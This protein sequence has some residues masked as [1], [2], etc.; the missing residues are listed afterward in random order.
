MTARGRFLPPARLIRGARRALAALGG[1]VLLAVAT[2][3]PAL[4]HIGDS[5]G[6]GVH[7]STLIA[8]PFALLAVVGVLSAAGYF[9]STAYRER[10]LPQDFD[11]TPSEPTG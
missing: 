5:Q 4:A 6:A 1:A 2:A 8:L 7:G 9:I 3:A 10:D 11:E